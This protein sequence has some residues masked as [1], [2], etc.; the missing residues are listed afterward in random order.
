MLGFIFL[1]RVFGWG[2]VI[3]VGHQQLSLRFVDEQVRCFSVDVLGDQLRRMVLPPGAAC[4]LKNRAITTTSIRPTKRPTGQV[5]AIERRWIVEGVESYPNSKC[6]AKYRIGSDGESKVASEESLWPVELPFN[7]DPIQK[8]ASADANPLLIFRARDNLVRSVDALVE[9]TG[10]LRALLTSCVDLLPHQIAVAGTILLDS[11][12]RYLL[13]DEVGLGKTIEAGLVIHDLLARNREARVLILAP[14]ALSQQWLAEMYSKFNRTVFRLLDLHGRFDAQKDQKAIASI[15]LAFAR[16]AEAIAAVDWDMI[17]VDE[18]HQLLAMQL[19]YRWVAKLAARCR[20]LLLLSAL[21]ARRRQKELLQLLALL[22]PQRYG[23]D[24]PPGAVPFDE[25]YAAQGDIGTIVSRLQERIKQLRATASGM[26]PA[27]DLIYEPQDVID[28]VGDLANA[29]IVRNDAQIVELAGSI[30]TEDPKFLDRAQEL[31]RLVVNRYRIHRRIVRN[32]RDQ[33]I[34]AEQVAAVKRDFR[35]CEYVAEAVEVEAHQSIAD[36]LTGCAAS[37]LDEDLLHSLARTLWYA[38]ATPHSAAEVLDAIAGA[39]PMELDPAQREWVTLTLM[40]AYTQWPDFIKLL[41]SAVR[42][43]TP[44]ELLREALGLVRRWRE[45]KVAE[46]ARRVLLH[47]LIQ[48]VRRSTPGAKIVVFAGFPCS[49]ERITEYLR[50]RLGDLTVAAFRFDLTPDEK[51]LEVRRFRRASGAQVLVC[52]ETGGEGRNFQFAT[53]LIHFDTPWSA[54]PVEQRI[55]RLDRLG[56]YEPVV[57]HAIMAKN[58]VES[59]LLACYR[60][61]LGVYHQSISGLEFALREVENSL[62]KAALAGGENALCALVPRL[63]DQALEERAKD[64]G[65]AL[66]DHT[67]QTDPILAPIKSKRMDGD[68]E[69]RLETCFLTFYRE[70]AESRAAAV[71]DPDIDDGIW[72]FSPERVPGLELGTLSQSDGMVREVTGTFSRKIAQQRP[73]L[74]FFTLSEPWFAAM[75]KMAKG[76]PLART[77]SVEYADLSG[78][79]W[80]GF[81]FIFRTHID[82]GLLDGHPGLQARARLICPPKQVSIFHRL[83]GDRLVKDRELLEFRRRLTFENRSQDGCNLR[84]DQWCDLRA[85]HAAAVV[86]TAGPDV[87]WPELV[88]AARQGAE[89]RGRE[90]VKEDFADGVQAALRSLTDL[91]QQYSRDLREDHADEI[92]GMALL[93]ETITNWTLKVEACGF[94]SINGQV[95]K[96]V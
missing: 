6:V 18:V 25:L 59:G 53:T 14:G 41:A 24:A 32:R 34:A 80:Q 64:A 76:G 78:R 27:A 65:E 16:H 33:L 52:D 74:R 56:R 47:S 93:E 9:T 85:D 22:D 58:T 90:R 95:R 11:N 1:H 61:G 68:L 54:A 67:T 57:S 36:L 91:R 62:A 48:E 45:H 89:E 26:I 20:G 43:S 40:P 31:L 94:L 63:K 10:G 30:V 86:V 13:A 17:V 7:T 21:P 44:P 96:Q 49:A 69:K 8:L 87:N 84:Q 29:P 39:E 82:L 77:Y 35:A 73:D 37:R 51:E 19:Q 75:L 3:E 50:T 88:N 92:A 71:R 23:P 81:E 5:D 15:D 83:T 28:V 60:E 46:A 72:R 42:A 38:S 55:G 79:K 2:K 4:T 12:Q 66:L 70:V